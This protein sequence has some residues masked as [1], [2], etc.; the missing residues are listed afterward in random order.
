MFNL[1]EEN[2]IVAMIER[3]VS[4]ADMCAVWEHVQEVTEGAEV[5]LCEGVSRC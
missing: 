2:I 4:P 3:G 5:N 1:F